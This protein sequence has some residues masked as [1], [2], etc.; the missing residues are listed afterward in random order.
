MFGVV[1][2]LCLDVDSRLWV[3]MTETRSVGVKRKRSQRLFVMLSRSFILLL[4][5]MIAR[6]LLVR[7]RVDTE[8]EN[9]SECC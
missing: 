8:I 4:K 5:M 2:L 7:C 1:R 9:Q 3:L 6:L